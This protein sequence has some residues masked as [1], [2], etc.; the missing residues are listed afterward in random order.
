MMNMKL[1]KI[2]VSVHA[3]NNLLTQTD[4]SESGIGFKCFIDKLI[5]NLVITRRSQPVL[6]ALRSLVR[7]GELVEEKNLIT[8]T[9]IIA[10]HLNNVI[11]NLIWNPFSHRRSWIPAGVYAVRS[12][13]RTPMRGYGAGMTIIRDR[14]FASFHSVQNDVWNVCRSVQNNKGHS[15]RNDVCHD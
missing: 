7:W 6:P 10:R 3:T 14:F 11:P 1:D 15:G 8:V 12:L 13:P 9:S 2:I 4:R 5:S